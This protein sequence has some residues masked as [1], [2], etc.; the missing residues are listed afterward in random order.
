M[1]IKDGGDCATVL[2]FFKS[3]PTA[4]RSNRTQTNKRIESKWVSTESSARTKSPRAEN[5]AGNPATAAL[6][7]FS[8]SPTLYDYHHNHYLYI[9]IYGVDVYLFKVSQLRA[10]ST[11]LEST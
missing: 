4:G 3:V 9:V 8:F 7:R 2:A 6:P 1:E 11:R 10:C 5:H